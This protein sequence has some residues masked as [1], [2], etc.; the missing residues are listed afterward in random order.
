MDDGSA[1]R[2]R[3]RRRARRCHRPSNAAAAVAFALVAALG[4]ASCSGG[5]DSSTAAST[6][7]TAP[8]TRIELP[9][10]NV[11]ADSPGAP[12]T[13]SADQS[14]RILDAVTTYVKGATVQPLRSGTPTT[15]DLSGLFD[16]GTLATA[17]TTDRGVVLDE[18]LPKVTG[19]LTI[20]AQPIGMVGLG[21]QSGHLALITTG[22]LLDVRGQTAV[23]DSPLH[24]V[25]RADLVLQP[26]PSGTWKITAYSMVVARDGAGLTPTTTSSATNTSGAAK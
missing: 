4:V 13:V 18:G 17:T 24:V 23:K 21:D 14:Q 7:T 22:L 12:V 3:V 20:T 26:D 9:L 6:S 25:R 10:G 2:S 15:A 1:I 11:S 16:T 5:G 8:T 19:D